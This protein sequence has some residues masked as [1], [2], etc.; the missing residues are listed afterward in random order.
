MC[1]D[2]GRQ[3][4]CQLIWQVATLRFS[5]LG[6]IK[7]S[8]PLNSRSPVI[9]H[10]KK[11]I[12]QMPSCKALNAFNERLKERR[13]VQRSFYQT[14]TCARKYYGHIV[15][16]TERERRRLSRFSTLP[17]KQSLHNYGKSICTIVRISFLEDLRITVAESGQNLIHFSQKIPRHDSRK[18]G[19]KTWSVRNVWQRNLLC[20]INL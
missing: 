11:G 20:I 3:E 4:D 19:V 15:A 18:L 7:R 12:K 9:M 16:G 14:L 5:F 13:K 1:P 8:V 17:L 10:I 2:N 6:F